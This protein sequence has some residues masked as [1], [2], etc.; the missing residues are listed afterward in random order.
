M[1]DEVEEFLRRVAQMRAQAEQQGQAQQPRQER[2]QPARQPR[3][4]PAA[5]P[6]PQPRP[7]RPPL[8]AGLPTSPIDVE[9]V[10]AELADTADRFGKRVQSDLRETE[11]IAEHTRHL[12]EEVDGADSKMQAHLH[13]VFDHK[14]GHLKSSGGE[15]A[16]V[17]AD[18]TA[19]ELS[20]DQIRRMLR[21]P[22]SVRDAIIMSEILRRPEF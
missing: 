9:I 15:T 4:P 20:L 14:L 7:S 17:T 18:R 11:Q 8:G 13:Q 10:D 5:R 2:Q 16:L 6:A 12:G 19:A 1:K 22:Q 21:S 3:K